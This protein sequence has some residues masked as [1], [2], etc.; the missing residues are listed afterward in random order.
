MSQEGPVKTGGKA[1]L[2]L[3]HTGKTQTYILH[4]GFPVFAALWMKLKFHR[5]DNNV[6]DGIIK[7][8]Q[9]LGKAFIPFFVFG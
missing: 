3:R 1:P 4:H 2:V 5:N 9:R 6:L 7:F 8:D